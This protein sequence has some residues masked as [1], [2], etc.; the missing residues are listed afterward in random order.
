M[1]EVYSVLSAVKDGMGRKDEAIE[2]LDRSPPWS[3]GTMD[4]Q[5]KGWLTIE[6][7]ERP[8]PMAQVVVHQVALR[9]APEGVP[10]FLTEG[11]KDSLRVLLTPCGYCLQPSRRQATGPAPKARCRPLPPLLYAQVSKTVRRRGLVRVS[12]RVVFGT[13]E[14][15]QPGLAGHGWQ[16]STAFV[17]RR[18]LNIRQPVAAVGR[19]VTTRCKRET[20]LRQ[21]L[22]LYQT[23][24]NFC[25]PHASLRQPLS[26]LE[27]TNGRGAAMQWRP[28]AVPLDLRKFGNE[29]LVVKHVSFHAV[30]LPH[31]AYAVKGI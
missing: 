31:L 9:L 20:G 23:S 2:P 26:Q 24:Y 27:P 19:R 30:T 6:V 8:G 15:V 1:D 5:R 4:P 28:P 12:H 18:N 13:R 21:Q 10:W 17:A 7:G 25:L 16:I 3:W 11:H 14:A 22:A 29:C